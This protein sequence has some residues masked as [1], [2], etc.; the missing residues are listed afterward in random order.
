MNYHINTREMSLYNI[1]K[2]P[3]LPTVRFVA[4]NACGHQCN[5]VHMY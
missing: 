3:Q 5:H 1:Q 4:I 2:W